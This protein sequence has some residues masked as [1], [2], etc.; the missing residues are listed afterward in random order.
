M[1]F[2]EN[3]KFRR[4]SNVV[5]REIGSELL[6]VPI[7]GGVGDLDAIF[8]FNG[9]GSDV[10]ALM[11]TDQ[12]IDVLAN[13]VV[14]HYEASRAQVEKDLSEFLSELVQAGLATMVPGPLV[15][16]LSLQENYASR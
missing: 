4:S 5:S 13:W 11:E 12:S 6:V 16:T 9:V 10:W 8:S 15:E 1:T 3:A 2:A 14:E 7:R